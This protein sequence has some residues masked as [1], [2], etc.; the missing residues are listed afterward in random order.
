LWPRPRIGAAHA[1]LV[2]LFRAFIFFALFAFALNNQQDGHRALVLRRGVAHAAWSSWCWW[3]LRRLR[4]RRAGHGAQLV[5]L[6]RMAQRH[7]TRRPAAGGAAGH[8]RCCLRSSA[9]E[10]PPRVG[11]LITPPAMDLDLQWLL[12][13]LPVAF[14]LGWMA[15][16]WT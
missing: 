3:P 1:L 15:S 13:G 14:A 6:R 2:W 16:R 8:P 11:P 10:H 12:I 9:A 5:A 4:D 7:G